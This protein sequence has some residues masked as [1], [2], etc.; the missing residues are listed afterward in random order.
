MNTKQLMQ[1]SES[2]IVFSTIAGQLK[3]A[4]MLYDEYCTKTL[5]SYYDG[6]LPHPFVML[7][8]E[9]I[10]IEL[11]NFAH[12]S[13]RYGKLMKQHVPAE[14]VKFKKRLR[15]EAWTKTVRN[16]LI[17]HKR[18]DKSEKFVSIQ[19]IYKMYH[20]DPNIVRQIGEELKNVL[21]TIV[22]FYT[23]ESWFPELGKLVIKQ[24]Y[25]PKNEEAKSEDPRTRATRG[26]SS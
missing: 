21:T 25:S 23:L 11:D 26:S 24:S 13:D 4:L 12:E 9:K 2:M 8:E 18:R 20:P 16:Q 3:Y 15:K 10:L 17:A 19:Q 5:V 7:A 6:K 1:L 22:T 14:Y